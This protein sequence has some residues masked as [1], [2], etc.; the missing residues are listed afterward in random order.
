MNQR[1][2]RIPES[3]DVVL[4]DFPGV[5]QTKRRPAVIVS[6]ALYHQQRPDVVLGLITSQI[7]GATAATDHI[8]Q[9]WAHVGL[10]QPSA[11]RTFLATVPRS[12]ISR[13]I[14]KLSTRD[15]RSVLK[16]LHLAL[17]GSDQ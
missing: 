15:W 1:R 16:C 2:K 14:G 3:G 8:L 17:A 13:R 5:K 11:Y 6:S 12:A 4:L 7:V 9:D 10:R